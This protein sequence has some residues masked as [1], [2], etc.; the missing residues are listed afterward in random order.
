M[1]MREISRAC[2][3][4]WGGHLLIGLLE[5]IEAGG[6]C[7]GPVSKQVGQVQMY[8]EVMLSF[9]LAHPAEEGAPWIS[10]QP[11]LTIGI[12]PTR[13]EAI[14]VCRRIDTSGLNGSSLPLINI[15]PLEFLLPL[16]IFSEY[17]HQIYPFIEMSDLR[18]NRLLKSELFESASARKSHGLQ[19][20][21]LDL[22]AENGFVIA[23]LLP[24]QVLPISTVFHQF[25]PFISEKNTLPPL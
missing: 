11:H 23:P 8:I 1:V 16:N 5:D 12:G 14:P 10:P 6:W 7:S 2:Q 25:L 22:L 9:V 17:E 13:R 24:R 4:S 3:I 15:L 19:T 20:S 18:L 21:L